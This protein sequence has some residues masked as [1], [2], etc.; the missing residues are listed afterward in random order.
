MGWKPPCEM[1][2]AGTSRASGLP[3][4]AGPP[5]G[6]DAVRR[7]SWRRSRAAD[8]RDRRVAF[9]ECRPARR[10]GRAGQACRARQPLHRAARPCRAGTKTRTC[11][12]RSSGRPSRRPKRASARCASRT[13]ERP[14]AAYPDHPGRVCVSENASRQAGQE[15]QPCA[16]LR[17]RTVSSPLFAPEPGQRSRRP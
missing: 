14:I 12:D 16:W 1:T 11:L 9:R 3:P 15:T 13:G 17:A 4:T 6:V 8:G 10:C 2:S 5:C 7:K